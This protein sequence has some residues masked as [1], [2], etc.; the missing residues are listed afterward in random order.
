MRVALRPKE[1]TSWD[2][3]SAKAW[4]WGALVCLALAYCGPY[5][6][7][8][9]SPGPLRAVWAAEVPEAQQVTVCVAAAAILTL[10]ALRGGR[11][12]RILLLPMWAL[13]VLG[14]GLVLA[15]SF[16]QGRSGL[17]LRMHWVAALMAL[18]AVAQ[19]GALGKRP[20]SK[21]P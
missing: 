19:A 20:W 8:R 16:S 5:R 3:S 11:T 2:R 13:A 6:L 18:A 9:T 1:R 17:G 12:P 4:A 14:L 7:L 10:V 21:K 15:A